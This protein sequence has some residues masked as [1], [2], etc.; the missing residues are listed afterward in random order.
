MEAISLKKR[1]SMKLLE[2]WSRLH[3]SSIVWTGGPCTSKNLGRVVSKSMID[4]LIRS[5]KHR[6]ASQFSSHDHTVFLAGDS[7]HTHS[8]GAGQGM[9]TGLSD[10]FNL[11]WKL[12]GVLRGFYEPS[13]LD[14]YETERK[15]VA[16]NLIKI[17]KTL[18]ALSNGDIPA[19]LEGQG[20]DAGTLLAA[21]FDASAAHLVG[22]GIRY[23][24]NAVNKAPVVGSLHAGQRGPDAPLHKPGQPFPVRLLEV[25]TNVGAFW[26]IVFAGR[27]DATRA[28]LQSLRHYVDGSTS[29]LRTANIEAVKFMTIISGEGVSPDE[30]LGVDKFGQAYWDR[31]GTAHLRYGI[32]EHAGAVVV[33]RPDGYFAFATALDKGDDLRRYFDGI[34]RKT[35]T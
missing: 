23:E 26:I 30:T 17:D 1:L 14:T 28:A 5:V 6:V 10:A 7:C 19:E 13:I 34:I 2:G 8:S 29:F 35:P 24:A 27:P 25:A 22:L 4:I 3:S 31:D 12:G 11:S 16:E 18:A 32:S 15:P 20:Q 21:T 9:N 33:L